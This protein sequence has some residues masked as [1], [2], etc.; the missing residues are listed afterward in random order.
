MGV[1][2]PVESQPRGLPL[3]ASWPRCACAARSDDGEVFTSSAYPYW[4]RFVTGTGGLRFG[5]SSGNCCPPVGLWGSMI[6]PIARVALKRPAY[7]APL[8]PNDSHGEPL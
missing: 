5:G 4:P 3:A 8:P 1:R 6:E 2:A 7:G